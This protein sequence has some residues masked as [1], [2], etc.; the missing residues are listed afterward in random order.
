MNWLRN[1]RVLQMLESMS[2]FDLL[3]RAATAGPL[4]LA[5]G[6]LVWRYRTVE[7]ISLAALCLCLACYLGL[8][9]PS[10]N[11]FPTLRL[12]TLTGTDFAGI[13][14]W[15]YAI[16]AFNSRCHTQHWSRWFKAVV[17]VFLLWHAFYFLLLGAQGLYHIFSHALAVGL[18]M[19][20]LWLAVRGFSEELSS[21]YRLV[22]VCIT[23]VAGA[24]MLFLA[25]NEFTRS[26]PVRQPV[27]SL[28]T[29]GL[30]FAFVYGVCL[31]TLGALSAE[32]RSKAISKTPV[33][34]TT[35]QNPVYRKL[36]AFIDAG[37]YSESDMTIAS[38]ARS[39]DVP[40]HKLRRVIN[41][42]LGY[43]NFSQFLNHYRIARAQKQLADPALRDT[44]ILTLAL[45]LGYGS[46]GPFNRAF[47]KQTGLTP[48]QFRLS[49]R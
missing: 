4:L 3:L 18:S 11:T 5:A 24:L 19:H 23:L 39:L 10:A 44:P 30:L 38:L 7:H 15:F 34:T 43:R 25:V 40:E 47:R 1:N 8:T 42:Q 46:I 37:R 41:Q 16:H 9:A 27:I 12:I 22:R 48:S 21:G 13:A 45:E 2:Y 29:A 49:A 36:Q 20:V 28:I 17:T 14:L 33:K 31:A 35:D 32:Q 26:V 6:L